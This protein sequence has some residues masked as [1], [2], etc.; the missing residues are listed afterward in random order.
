MNSKLYLSFAAGVAVGAVAT[1]FVVKDRIMQQAQEEIDSVKEVFKKHH[2]VPIDKEEQEKKELARENREKPDI[3]TY[4]NILKKE[5]YVDYS[6]SAEREEEKETKKV[7]KFGKDIPY[8]IAPEDF[9]ENEDYEKVSYTY[10][11]DGVVTDEREEIVK[12][13]GET[14]GEDFADHFGDYE[15]DSVYIRNDVIGI[16]YEILYDD[17]TY[18][19]VHG[20]RSVEGQ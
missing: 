13:V 10:Y 15:D 2:L 5:G 6:Q 16:D 4:S 11:S 3:M 1:Y 19:E 9:G 17:R 7:N 14:I 8:V 18:E 12:D 20:P